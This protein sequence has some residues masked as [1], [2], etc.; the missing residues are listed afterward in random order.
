M[1]AIPL[2][3]HRTSSGGM[4]SGPLALLAEVSDYVLSSTELSADKDALAP[5]LEVRDHIG[6]QLDG[7]MPLSAIRSLVEDLVEQDPRSASAS[8]YLE[9]LVHLLEEATGHGS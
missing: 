3:S 4:I 5:F 9:Q 6:Q 1:R 2:G 8:Q 7:G